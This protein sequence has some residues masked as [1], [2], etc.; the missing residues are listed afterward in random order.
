MIRDIFEYVF[1]RRRYRVLRVCTVPASRTAWPVVRP[2]RPEAVIVYSIGQ[3]LRGS[4]EQFV[5]SNR[6]L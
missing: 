5:P 2:Y 3:A 1:G 6:I 4:R